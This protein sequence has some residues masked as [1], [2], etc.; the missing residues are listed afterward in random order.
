MEVLQ[1]FRDRT[2]LIFTFSFP[3]MLL[4][5]FGAIFGDAYD[6]SPAS[7]SAQVFSASMIAYGI[8]STAF[9]TMGAGIAMDR[10]DGTLKRLRGTPMTST[11]YLLGKLIFGLGA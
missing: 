7:A 9:V 1:F 3:A 11:A 6:A 8:L 10:E 2:A 4:L 5:L